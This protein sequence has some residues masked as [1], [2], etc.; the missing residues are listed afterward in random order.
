MAK[1]SSGRTRQGFRRRGCRAAHPGAAAPGRRSGWGA[2]RHGRPAAAGD[3][4][5]REPRPDGATRSLSRAGHVKPG[6]NLGGPPSKPEYYP[7]T[8]SAPVP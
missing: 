5:V 3:S 2:E 8:D 4:P 7:V 1:P 6:P